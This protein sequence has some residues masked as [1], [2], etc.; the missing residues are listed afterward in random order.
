MRR[1]GTPVLVDLLDHIVQAI[2]RI[3]RYTGDVDQTAFLAN[4]EKQ[5]AVIRNFE[6]IGEAAANIA[7]RYPDFIAQ[8][9]AFRWQD[10]YGMR[11]ILAHGYFKVDLDLVWKTTGAD[12]AA[13]KARVQALRAPL[14]GRDQDLP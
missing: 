2:E 11:N 13:L 14:A 6:I 10:A 3:E 9:P 12:L 7:R 1:A 4:E 5:D 8:H